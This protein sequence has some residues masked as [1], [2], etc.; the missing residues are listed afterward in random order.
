MFNHFWLGIFLGMLGVIFL[1]QA[2]QWIEN[3]LQFQLSSKIKTGLSAAILVASGFASSHYAEVD[4]VIAYQKKI[5]FNKKEQAR[6]EEERIEKMRVDSLNFYLE[7]ADKLSV[8]KQF[9]QAIEAYGLALNFAEQ[10]E[11]TNIL[12]KKA[13]CLVSSGKY[14]AAILEITSLLDVGQSNSYLYLQRAICYNKKGKTG[15]AVSDLQTAIEM[16]NTDAN[17]LYNKINPVRRRIIGYQTRCCDGSI[18]Y[19]RGRGACSHHG[20]VCNWNDPIYQEY[21]KYE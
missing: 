6:I 10:V 3:K 20:G 14:E 8:K 21:R 7:K 16:G 9:N 15:D 2:Q 19:A 4:K 5:E 1:P 11:R 12:S 18:S 17:E 13:S